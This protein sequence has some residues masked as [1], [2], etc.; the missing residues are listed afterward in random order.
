LKCLEQCGFPVPFASRFKV[1]L[2]SRIFNPKKR[3]LQ[4]SKILPFFEH[5][6][7]VPTL[8]HIPLNPT[9]KLSTFTYMNRIPFSRPTAN[10][11]FCPLLLP[12]KSEKIVQ[13]IK[14]R[15]C[16]LSAGFTLLLLHSPI[17]SSETTTS[18]LDQ[19]LQATA[20]I[21]SLNTTEDPQTHHHNATAHHLTERGNHPSVKECLDKNKFWIGDFDNHHPYQIV[22]CAH[23]HAPRM[24]CLDYGDDDLHVEEVGK[25][26]KAPG[27]YNHGPF[28]AKLKYH[29][30]HSYDI[31]GH[32]N[33]HTTGHGRFSREGMDMLEKYVSDYR[34]RYHCV[35]DP[36]GKWQCTGQLNWDKVYSRIWP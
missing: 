14:M 24:H 25:C 28:C 27:R 10:F 23:A 12:Q 20:N 1:M 17:V 30:S 34:R 2:S 13:N 9:S 33:G 19:T 35:Q 16:S 36:T 3:S 8:R 15:V 5:S 21:T 31:H 6:P 22:C 29:S 18:A 32:L 7:K 11:A 26:E 4:S